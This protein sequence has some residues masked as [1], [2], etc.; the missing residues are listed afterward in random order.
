MNFT[1]KP[2]IDPAFLARIE[3]PTESLE[4]VKKQ[5]ESIQDDRVNRTGGLRE[6][7]V[8][9]NPSRNTVLMERQR[10]NHANG[11]LLHVIIAMEGGK[12]ILYLDWST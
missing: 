2:P 4:S 6:R 3:I 5:L 9:W 7:T 12:V 1:Y 8:W 10:V 11:Q